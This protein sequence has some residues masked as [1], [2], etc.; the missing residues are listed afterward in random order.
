MIEI[1]TQDKRETFMRAVY[2]HAL[3][4]K[5]PRT[6][7]GAVLV[8]ENNIIST[9]FNNFPRK[10]KDYEERYTDRI[11]KYSFIVHGE[12]NA[13]LTA[14]RLGTNTLGSTL[15]TQGVPC[16]ECMKSII[17]AGCVKVVVHKQWPNLDYSEK[18]VEA[19]RISKIMVDESGVELEWFDKKLGIIGF[20]DG[21]EINV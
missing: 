13:I 1:P 12:H 20:F 16:C 11:T 5:D 7:I 15:Y 9:G 18:W 21:K 2:L 19:T 3:S 14:A 10:V 6:K 8:R 17:Q 4:S